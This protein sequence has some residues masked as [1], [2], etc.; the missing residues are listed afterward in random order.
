MW[1]LAYFY[2]Y[3]ATAQPATAIMADQQQQQPATQD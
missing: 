1:D 3:R 2:Q